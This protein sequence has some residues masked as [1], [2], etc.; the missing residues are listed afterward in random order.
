MSCAVFC[1]RSGG[2]A[3]AGGVIDLFA[4]DPE[5][6]KLLDR[7]LLLEEQRRRDREAL[8]RDA[9]ENAVRMA[10]EEEE[11]RARAE[12]ERAAAAARGE[13]RYA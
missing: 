5:K 4:T 11:A 2:G 8:R 1:R 7:A 6:I 10:K 9:E 3:G 12:E 13:V